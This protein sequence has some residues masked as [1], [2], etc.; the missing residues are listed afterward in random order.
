[1]NYL[2]LINAVLREVNEVELVTIASSRGIQTS[3]SDFINKAQRDIINS[4]VEWPFTIVSASF[5]TT[6]S[7]AEYTPPAA[8][9]TIDFDTFT[10]QESASTAEKSLSYLSFNEYIEHY[11]EVDTN[12]NGDSEGLPRYVY[13]TPDEKIGLSPVPDVATYTVRYYYYATHTDMSAATDTP[14]IPERF[15]DV[16]VNRARYYTHMLRSDTQFSQLALRDYEQG[17]NRMRVE[18]INRKDYMRAV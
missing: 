12:P 18:L 16:I 4:E 15:H 9:K 1:M 2:Q 7:T 13:F 17:L 14:T 8:A 3:V 5:T 11:N 6:A 10:V